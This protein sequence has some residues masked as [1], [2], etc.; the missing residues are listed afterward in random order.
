MAQDRIADI[1]RDAGPGSERGDR[2]LAPRNA[3]VSTTEAG[4]DPDVPAPES[5]AEE[6]PA[7]QPGPEADP[8]VDVKLSLDKLGNLGSAIGALSFL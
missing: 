6:S 7:E 3:P 5:Q 4:R 2:R 1:A 8:P